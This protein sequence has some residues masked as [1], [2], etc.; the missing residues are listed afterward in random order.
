[1]KKLPGILLGTALLA[2]TLSVSADESHHS[3]GEVLDDTMVTTKVKAA[4]VGDPLTKAH[5]IS[6]D[7]YKGTVK[8]SGF[9]DT[10]AAKQRAVEVAR[11]IKGAAR[12]EDNLEVRE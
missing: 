12:V 10:L 3:A 4:L 9:V 5:Q 6:V 7:T 11:D 8:L 1:M 2:C